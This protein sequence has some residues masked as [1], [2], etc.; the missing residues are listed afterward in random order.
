[1][2][3]AIYIIG[4]GAIGKT[5]AVFLQEA[6]KN[7]VLLRGREVNGPAYV[8]E[9]SVELGEGTIIREKIKVHTIQKFKKLEGIIVLTN[10]SF[11]NEAIASM[12]KDKIYES[13][14]ILLQNG[15]YIEKIFSDL[16]FSSIYRGVLLATSQLLSNNLLR[17][18]PVRTSPVGIIQSDTNE[19]SRVVEHL[20]NPY[21]EFNAV[22]DII[23][24]VWSKA[25]VNVVF[26]S[27]CPLLET[28]NGIFCRNLSALEIA[29]R[30]I[31]ECTKIARLNKVFLDL[32][33]V[34]NTLLQISRLS[35]GQFI[36]TYQDIKAKRTTEID[37][38]NFAITN[39]ADEL[40]LS[41]TVKE[42]KLLGELVKIKSA[43]SML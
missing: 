11:G 37:T 10:K 7:V 41:D 3:S 24:F 6:G 13:P 34:L 8:E 9:L 43:L 18:K 2:G 20:S 27:V 4:A 42:T 35:D 15:L 1:M 33:E 39:H 23:P 14:V 26:N 36:S 29:K 12:I 32:Q 40:Q 5:L 17:F 30:V 21:F 31:V 16:G 25:I 19:L 38:L 28:D 22:Q